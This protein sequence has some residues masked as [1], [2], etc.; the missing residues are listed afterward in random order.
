MKSPTICATPRTPIHCATVAT[1]KAYTPVQNTCTAA[2]RKTA[3][4]D[5]FETASSHSSLMQKIAT[6][7]SFD[8][9]KMKSKSGSR[10]TYT[11]KHKK[12]PSWPTISRS[13]ISW[14][15]T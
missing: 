15:A 6:L 8:S 11:N 2:A 9:R 4:A 10:N 5:A 7:P 12:E 14:S 1:H 13:A 3:D